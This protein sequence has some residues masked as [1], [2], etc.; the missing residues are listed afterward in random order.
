MPGAIHQNHIFRVRVTEDSV[1][2][3]YLSHLLS[4]PYGRKYFLK[5]A[6]QTTGIASINKTQLSDFPVMLPAKLTQL[7]FMERLEAYEA[8]KVRYGS[9]LN[10]VENL[11]SS[12]QSRAFVGEL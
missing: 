9:N 11:F 3:V 6:K 7:E 8:Q 1:E 2:P 12:L 5:M 10:K 4:S